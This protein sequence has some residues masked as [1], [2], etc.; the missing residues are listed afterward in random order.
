MQ[1]WEVICLKGESSSGLLQK[2]INWDLEKICS[3]GLMANNSLPSG[4][5]TPLSLLPMDI[6][7]SPQSCTILPP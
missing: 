5:H 1:C 6:V 4:P 2:T 3:E 7:W